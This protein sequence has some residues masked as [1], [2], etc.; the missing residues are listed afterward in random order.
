MDSEKPEKIFDI[1]GYL[2]KAPEEEL[3][4]PEKQSVEPEKAGEIGAEA[5]DVAEKTAIDPVQQKLKRNRMIVGLVLG[6]IALIAGVFVLIDL[7]DKHSFLER[8]RENYRQTLATLKD[9]EKAFDEAFKEYSYSVYG[10]SGAP[11]ASDIYPTEK[12]MTAASHNCLRHFDIDLREF[13]LLKKR[14]EEKDD[15]V[16]ANDEYG[17]ISSNYTRAAASLDVCRQDIL[18]PIVSAFS[19]EYG[20]I[21]FEPSKTGYLVYLPSK[22]GYTGDRPIM[23]AALSFAL[24]DKSGRVV[25]GT[26]GYLEKSFDDTVNTIRKIDFDPFQIK[27]QNGGVMRQSIGES[28]KGKY[29]SNELGVYSISG[30]FQIADD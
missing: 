21:R 2:G 27:A 4:T 30:K 25:V 13:A 26:K 6:T 29:L 16:E 12:E 1:D 11:K 10:L 28:D 9:N 17:R 5:V 14:D 20:E 23:N 18:E 7:I 24:Y 19:I 22:I 3:I 8:S 15:Y